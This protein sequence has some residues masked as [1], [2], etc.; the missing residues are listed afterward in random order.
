[1]CVIAM[2]G[3]VWL[4]GFMH[5]DLFGDILPITSLGFSR[6][7]FLTSVVSISYFVVV[8]CDLLISLMEKK[9]ATRTTH[10]SAI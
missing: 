8:L 10:G 1:M 5:L 7:T 9:K 4:T 2:T 6:L 3:L